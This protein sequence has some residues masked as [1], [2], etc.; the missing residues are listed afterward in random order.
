[1]SLMQLKS[2]FL[3]A[4]WG[5]KDP[6]EVLSACQTCGDLIIV[7]LTE[8][9]GSKTQAGFVAVCDVCHP[10]LYEKPQAK[11]RMPETRLLIGYACAFLNTEMHPYQENIFNKLHSALENERNRI[12]TRTTLH[13][14]VANAV[15][16]ILG[17]AFI[18]QLRPDMFKAVAWT[19]A[20]ISMV[21]CWKWFI[22]EA[23]GATFQAWYSF[24][25]SV[26]EKFLS[27][28][29]VHELLRSQESPPSSNYW[30]S[31]LASYN[32]RRWGLV[33][34]L[35]LG[36]TDLIYQQYI[37]PLLYFLIPLA[38]A[39]VAQIYSP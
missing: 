34:R 30:T 23:Q 39:L 29:F 13:F 31:Y 19:L 4:K 3:R 38:I 17:L 36:S 33:G 5:F 37:L 8:K 20:L 21:V 9:D 35:L 18:A 10:G 32:R 11:H 28:T 2:D 25:N 22:L 1:M 24:Y 7:V 14:T 15:V 12:W 6:V 16:A 27:G 26:W